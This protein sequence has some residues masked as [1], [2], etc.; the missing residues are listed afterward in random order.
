MRNST[1][2]IFIL[3]ILGLAALVLVLDTDGQVAG[4]P[5]DD[6]AQLVYLGAIGAVLGTSMLFMFRGHFAQAVRSALL[7]VC[8]FAVLIMGYTFSSEFESVGQRMLGALVPGRNV[9][10]T[11]DGQQ[12]IS[13]ARGFDR[14]F[15]VNG[16]VNGVDVSFLVDTGA[17]TI[18]F[19]R[20]MARRIGVDPDSLSYTAQ[21]RTANGIASAALIRLDTVSIGPITR[22]NVNA[23]V[24]DGDGI[25]MALLGMSFLGQLASVEF[26][27]DRLILTD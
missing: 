19:D 4:L 14:H 13:V 1:I 15:N 22:R 17:S 7:W 5:A 18:A 27:G 3:A 9:V 24:T 21:V 8:A 10:S 12:Q 2:L 26:R 11:V 23:L 6:F 25:G 20:E 16:Q